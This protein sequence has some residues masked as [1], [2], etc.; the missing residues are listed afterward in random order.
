MTSVLTLIV[1]VVT[2]AVTGTEPAG[3][4]LLAAVPVSPAP[5]VLGKSSTL[6]AVLAISVAGGLGP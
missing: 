4:S 2:A 5:V 1:L 3:C 6:I